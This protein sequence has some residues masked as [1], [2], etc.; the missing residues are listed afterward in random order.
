MHHQCFE[1]QYV[2]GI[3]CVPCFLAVSLALI[4]CVQ[5]AKLKWAY[6]GLRF[7]GV[8]WAQFWGC[9]HLMRGQCIICGGRTE[10]CQRVLS[11]GS[12]NGPIHGEVVFLCYDSFCFMVMPLFVLGVV[13]GLWG[14][15]AIVV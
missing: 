8:A 3:F 12:A 14:S 4:N 9:G 15:A 2:R 10:S 5:A 11:A 7:S 1:R 13:E 6:R